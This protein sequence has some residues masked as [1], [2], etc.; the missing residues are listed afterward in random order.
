MKTL[1][2]I[3]TLVVSS[4]VAAREK[5]RDL[6]CTAVNALGKSEMT[7]SPSDRSILTVFDNGR[8]SLTL[9]SAY[10]VETSVANV[11]N[12]EP[13]YSS[14]TM[15]SPSESNS[16]YRVNYSILFNKVAQPGKVNKMKGVL[17]RIQGIR[18]PFTTTVATVSCDLTLQ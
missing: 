7:Y 3:L 16:F 10:Y 11:N 17:Q 18:V 15:A 13:I 4:Q 2:I 9:T 8:S 12:D 1:L 5:I 6:K 14:V